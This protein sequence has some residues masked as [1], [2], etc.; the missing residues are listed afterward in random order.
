[1]N[2]SSALVQCCGPSHHVG[3]NS[4]ISILRSQVKRITLKF[5]ALSKVSL[6]RRS[7]QWLW[8]CLCFS[9]VDAQ[10]GPVVGYHQEVLVHGFTEPSSVQLWRNNGG[11]LSWRYHT[12]QKHFVTL[13]V[14][15]GAKRVIY[16]LYLPWTCDFH[17]K[18]PACKT[19]YNKQRQSVRV[20]VSPNHFYSK[21]NVQARA[22]ARPFIGEHP[23]Y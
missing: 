2:D 1:M 13:S 21:K 3:P 16:K 14:T 8:R 10:T 7:R 11:H 17:A 23:S 6:Q 9:A 20:W 19:V 12:T 18:A 22:M 5:R 15:V 4:N